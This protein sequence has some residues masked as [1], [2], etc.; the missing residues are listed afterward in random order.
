MIDR[1]RNSDHHAAANRSIISDVIELTELQ[2]ELF[3]TDA[4]Q[5]FQQW[6]R[7]VIVLIAGV[8]MLV[9]T[10][11]VGLA[12]VAIGLH[13]SLGLSWLW[14]FTA[15]TVAGIVIA[16]ACIV[17]AA[18]RMASRQQLFQQSKAELK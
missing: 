16:V 18:M 7:W 1:N 2:C 12:A 9:G 11:S 14:S 15:V 13:Q 17:L 6:L 3:V 8:A 10:V 4:R 5:L